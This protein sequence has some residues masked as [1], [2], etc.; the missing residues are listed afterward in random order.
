MVSR[1][2]WSSRVVPECPPGPASQCA[3]HACADTRSG[4][5]TLV[6]ACREVWSANREPSLPRSFVMAGRT[7]IRI[8]VVGRAFAPRVNEFV[9]V[10]VLGGVALLGATVAALVWAN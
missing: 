3:V 8:P 5:L 1:P 9:A 7:H 2:R 6:L 10:E 4:W